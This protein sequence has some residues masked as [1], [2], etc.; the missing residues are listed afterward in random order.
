MLA[1][2]I[3]IVHDYSGYKL[4]GVVLTL[5]V[6]TSCND[7]LED[8]AEP[9]PTVAVE[10]AP[11][12][13]TRSQDIETRAMFVRNHGLGYSYNT[14]RGEY[15]KWEDIRCQ[16]VDRFALEKYCKD[17][18]SNFVVFDKKTYSSDKSSFKYSL[19]DYVASVNMHLDEEVDLGL[20][21]KSKRADQY[22]IE[23]GVEETFY[24]TTSQLHILGKSQLAY[25]DLLD[26]VRDDNE[27]QLLTPSFRA[28]VEHVQKYFDD[29]IAVIDSFINI[30]GTH[31][32][33]QAFLGGE[34][35]ISLQNYVWRYKD[36]AKDSV[37]TTQQF[38][39]ECK[40]K[41][42]QRTKDGF[43]WIEHGKLII[44]AKGGDQSSLTNLLGKYQV[45]GKRTFSI[46]GVSKWTTSFHYDPD[47]DM[48]SNVE[49]VDMKV[50]P[51]W[52]F[53]EAVSPVAAQYIKAAILQDVNYM[54]KLLGENNFYDTSFPAFYDTLRCEVQTQSGQWTTV[55]RIDSKE[56]PMLVNVESGG[57]IVAV[58]SHEQ[59][60]K[61]WFWVAYPVYE[62]VVNKL[63]AVAVSEATGMVYDV[64]WL[65]GM[66]L[67]Q[68]QK[69]GNAYV[70]CNNATFYMNAGKIM[71][72]PQEGITYNESHPM[73]YYAL[74][75]GI[76]YDGTY[77]ST[78]LPVEKQ[79]DTYI[80]RN[81]DP[82]L[83]DIVG[84]SYDEKLKAYRRQDKYT[85]IYNP[86]EMRVWE[87]K[88]VEDLLPNEE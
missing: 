38:L 86:N 3:T 15:S 8:Y 13:W 25:A 70:Y 83:T 37:I 53:A 63:C 62:S 6:L 9:L 79:G 76:Q 21:S 41:E 87:S 61:N 27:K 10:A 51:I 49:M 50:V 34:L 29:D 40:D 82:S 16:V 45:D 31:V 23:N 69:K 43:T 80:I 66:A 73:P 44:N 20:Y 26:R 71:V 84:F 30:W 14:V 1:K 2:L 32:I 36:T 19:R 59:I 52:T 81:E 24:Y 75:G 85:Y 65:E 56:M 12:Q 22:F 58:V 72:E 55:E 7:Y 60:N 64:R 54:Q 67:I 11:F 88:T 42:E 28:S 78:A 4:A 33:V 18:K 74:S 17:T 46:D 5:L 68:P 39:D 35:N 48:A 57:R 77:R 47:D